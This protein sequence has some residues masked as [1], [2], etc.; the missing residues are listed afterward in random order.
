[1][2]GIASAAFETMH[3]AGLHCSCGSP[4]LIAV[5]PGREP[6]GVAQLG[7]FAPRPANYDRGEPTRGWCPKC[8]P[9]LRT[10]PLAEAAE[11]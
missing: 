5:V 1:M 4:D 11:A 10:S 3:I 6:E 7:S 2:S 9:V 8:W